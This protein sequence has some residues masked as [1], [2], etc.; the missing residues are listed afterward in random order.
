MTKAETIII[1]NFLDKRAGMWNATLIAT[2][3]LNQSI[4]SILRSDEKKG[5]NDSLTRISI[6]LLPETGGK[7]RNI[8]IELGFHT[9]LESLFILKYT[10]KN[11]NEYTGINELLLWQ[12][13]SEAHRLKAKEIKGSVNMKELNND[14]LLAFTHFEFDIK[15]ENKRLDL[16]RP[17]KIN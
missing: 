1:Q 6:H 10:S 17:M 9:T 15:N 14:A 16:F 3:R 13:M 11:T 12:L 7:P 4:Y 5:R 8:Q 2:G